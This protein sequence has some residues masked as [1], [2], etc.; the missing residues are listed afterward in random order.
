MTGP[1]VTIRPATA[2]DAGV[3][4]ELIQGLA[5]YERLRHECVATEAL[6]RDTLFGPRPY[7]EVIIADVQEAAAGFALYFHNYSTFLSRP[8]IYLEDLYVRP[9]FRG[10]GIGK[11]LL[12]QL[13]AIAVARQCGRLEW[14]VLDWNVDAIGFYKK[15]GAVPQ[16]EWTVYRVTGD[17]LTQLATP[18]D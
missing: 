4:L 9:E 2:A 10:M 7:A 13:A 16:D 17:A 5:E 1:A 3:I 18:T 6:L 15:L 8:G 11:R 12:Q 14:S